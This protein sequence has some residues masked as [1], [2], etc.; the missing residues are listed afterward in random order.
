MNKK[1]KNMS[2]NKIEKILGKCFF[3]SDHMIE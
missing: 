2:K 3:F 1:T